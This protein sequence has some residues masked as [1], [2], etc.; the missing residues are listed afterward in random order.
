MNWK[1]SFHYK[2][3]G[4]TTKY[5]HHWLPEHNE[6]LLPFPLPENG[7]MPNYYEEFDTL[8]HVTT[9]ENAAEILRNGFKPKCI[10]D[11]SVAN[12]E[13]DLFYAE[14]DDLV[15]PRPD[16]PIQNEEVIWYGPRTFKKVRDPASPVERYGNVVFAMK[17]LEGYEGLI[18]KGS[19][20]YEEMNLY[21]IE[22][23]EYKTQSACRILVTTKTYPTLRK[24]DPFTKGGPFYCDLQNNRFY[25]LKSIKRQNGEIIENL[26]AVEFMKEPTEYDFVDDYQNHVISFSDCIS[27]RHGV[28]VVDLESK[29]SMYDISLYLNMH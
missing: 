4:K 23:L 21:F 14:G 17:T 3:Y 9:F 2:S 29:S 1:K 16:H 5:Y 26:N 22:V 20:C 11:N 6:E 12:R 24:F 28:N 18:R 8:I 10:S 27:P 7:G 19:S 15:E 13:N 25:H